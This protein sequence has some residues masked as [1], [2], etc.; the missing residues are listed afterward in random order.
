MRRDYVDE[1][2]EAD[3]GP[4]DPVPLDSEILVFP[5]EQRNEL[6]QLYLADLGIDEENDE[7]GVDE[8]Y[9]EHLYDARRLLLGH[10]VEPLEL[11]QH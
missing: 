6:G 1:H 5:S 7:T 10:C 4:N 3:R 9:Q 2:G 8:L 11:R